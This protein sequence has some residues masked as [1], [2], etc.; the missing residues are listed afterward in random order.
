MEILNLP[1]SFRLVIL[2]IQPATTRLR[3]SFLAR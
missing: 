2:L 3:P 1:E